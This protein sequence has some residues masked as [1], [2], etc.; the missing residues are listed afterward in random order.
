MGIGTPTQMTLPAAA[1]GKKQVM[2]VLGVMTTGTRALLEPVTIT[3]M[4]LGLRARL[5]SPLLN[6][7][8]PIQLQVGMALLQ[9]TM[10]LL[11]VTGP[12]LVMQAPLMHL[13][14]VDGNHVTYS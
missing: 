3:G 9:V 12:V 5:T 2:L 1:I 10:A 13:R 6:H 7:H 8:L 14:P 11:L 4:I